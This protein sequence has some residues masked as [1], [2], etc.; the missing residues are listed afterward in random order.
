M[1]RTRGPG[2]YIVTYNSQGV[3]VT[4]NSW[5]TRTWGIVSD[6]R[7][8][9]SSEISPQA[10]MA[11]IWT[12]RYRPPQCPF[13]PRLSSPTGR[14]QQSPGHG[15]RVTGGRL[16]AGHCR[17]GRVQDGRHQDRLLR[18]FGTRRTCQ[19]SGQRRFLLNY[20]L[21]GQEAAFGQRW[22]M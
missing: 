5:G 21:A 7:Q 2:S 16:Q 14:L 11:S 8:S 3:R 10:N 15:R 1:S 4:R 18:L 13:P 22:L 20:C 9:Y 17:E 12:T 19:G 6:S